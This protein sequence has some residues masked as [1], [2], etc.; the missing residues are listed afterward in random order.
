MFR[1]IAAAALLLLT[2]CERA[3]Q[4][5]QPAN[6]QASAAPSMAPILATPD[7]VD[8]H[9]FAKPLEARVHHVALDINVD[10]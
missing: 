3:G 6:E 5:P 1:T 7:A 4:A 8:A 2:A 10:F 9:S